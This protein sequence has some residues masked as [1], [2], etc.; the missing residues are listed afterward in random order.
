MLRQLIDDFN[1]DIDAALASQRG[2]DLYGRLW[3]LL[4]GE[5]SNDEA[6]IKAEFDKQADMLVNVVNYSLET[7]MTDI[8]TDAIKQVLWDKLAGTDGILTLDEL[9][10]L[11]KV[12]GEN[13]SK[14]MRDG[15]E[16]SDLGPAVAKAAEKITDQLRR[17]IAEQAGKTS[18]ME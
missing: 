1:H 16:G 2:Q 9:Q 10:G 4:I 18:W 5:Y 8:Q 12:F 6:A 17:E 14:I 3:N 7:A 15:V 13:F 11:G